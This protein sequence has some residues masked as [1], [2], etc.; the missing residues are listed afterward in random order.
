MEIGLRFCLSDT[1]LLPTCCVHT[2]YIYRANL[3]DGIPNKLAN[4]AQPIAHNHERKKKYMNKSNESF[5]MRIRM[6][7]HKTKSIEN[8]V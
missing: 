8:K 3:F 1:Q 7:L 5:A 6:N 4:M 2:I